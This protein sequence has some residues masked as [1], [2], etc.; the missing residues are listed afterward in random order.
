MTR[1]EPAIEVRDLVCSHG[2]REILHGVDLRVEQGEM[3]GL[4]GPNGSGKTTLL[5][6]LSGA[7]TP[8]SGAVR[9]MGRDL[10]ELPGRDRARL[11]SAVPQSPAAVPGLKV[12]SLVLMGRYP[13]VSVWRG[14]GHE[15]RQ[16]AGQALHEAGLSGFADRDAGSLS[17]GERQRA[18]V[19]RALAQDTDLLL[20]DEASA[21]LDVR[22]RV[23]VHDFLVEHNRRGLTMVAAMH[24][25][26][27]A[28]LY[29]PRLVVVKA[30]RIVLDGPT[31]EVFTQAN[32][33]EVYETSL[34]IVAHPHTGT[35]QVLVRPGGDPAPGPRGRLGPGRDRRS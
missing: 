23:A 22:S 12:L 30:G 4:L 21:G 33:E 27:L 34:T 17:G 32:L 13:Y 11:V 6:T 29:C 18:Y 16:R 8:C 1:I 9:I 26:N 3:V 20:L 35:P 7:L 19:A 28:A 31:A 10:A 25:L 15:D 14:Y 5:L 24:D 2:R